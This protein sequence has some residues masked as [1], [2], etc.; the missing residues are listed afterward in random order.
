MNAALSSLLLKVVSFKFDASDGVLCPF[1]SA[2]SISNTA[3]FTS[4]IMI[5]ENLQLIVS[6]AVVFSNEFAVAKD[7]IVV[8]SGKLLIETG[9]SD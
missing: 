1:C 4:I 5:D 3:E 8:M 7:Y 2:L 6:L 9:R